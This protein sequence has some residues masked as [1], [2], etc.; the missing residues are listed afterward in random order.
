MFLGS[1][2]ILKIIFVHQCILNYMS[3]ILY[4][5]L[6]YNSCYS[7]DVI[8]LFIFLIKYNNYLLNNYY[9]LLFIFC[10][11]FLYVLSYK[12]LIKLRF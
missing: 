9:I 6:A 11:L 12:I 7:I 4:L 2:V 1:V 5:I 8:E 3:D 10:M